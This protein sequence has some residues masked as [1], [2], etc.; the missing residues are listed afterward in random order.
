MTSANAVDVSAASVLSPDATDSSVAALAQPIERSPI[1]APAAKR[2]RDVESVR[3]VEIMMPMYD[4]IA[5][6][7]PR[8]GK[9]RRSL[10]ESEP[11]R[12]GSTGQL[13]DEIR[14]GTDATARLHRAHDRA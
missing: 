4:P 11:D 14:F 12:A 8:V 13:D 5:V 3:I 7:F 2:G 10:A 6:M 1:H 9:R